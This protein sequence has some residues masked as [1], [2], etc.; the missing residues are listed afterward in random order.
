M[1]KHNRQWKG[2]NVACGPE[3]IIIHADM[4]SQGTP[5]PAPTVST[6]IDWCEV[7]DWLTWN[8]LD[9]YVFFVA[10]EEM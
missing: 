8:W 10:S 2:Q 7:S 9:I 6:V 4:R 3:K 5:I 1:M